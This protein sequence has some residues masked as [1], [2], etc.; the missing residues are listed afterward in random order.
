MTSPRVPE[1]DDW[2]LALGPARRYPYRTRI[3]SG[4][5]ELKDGVYLLKFAIALVWK[6]K[7]LP[8]RDWERW[9]DGSVVLYPWV[10]WAGYK[11]P[12]MEII[13]PPKPQWMPA[14]QWVQLIGQGQCRPLHRYYDRINLE[15]AMDTVQVVRRNR[16]EIR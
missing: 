10:W 5:H 4:L 6:P 2:D 13:G 1:Y 16:R 8:N 9:Q 12:S 11:T 14:V 3:D 7:R 15:G